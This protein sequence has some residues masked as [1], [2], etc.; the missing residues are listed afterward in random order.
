MQKVEQTKSCV[1]IVITRCNF[2]PLERKFNLEKKD[3]DDFIVRQIT[4]PSHRSLFAYCLKS[5]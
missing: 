4:S 3:I 2:L 5:Y 1:K